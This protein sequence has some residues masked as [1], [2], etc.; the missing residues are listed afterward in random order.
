MGH[1]FQER[2][3]KKHTYLA[4]PEQSVLKE[5]DGTPVDLHPKSMDASKPSEM[6]T[7]TP[8]VATGNALESDYSTMQVINK[9]EEAVE[10]TVLRTFGM[11]RDRFE[12]QHEQCQR[13]D[14]Q[15]H[16]HY[17]GTTSSGVNSAS[18]HHF[19][20]DQCG[21]EIQEYHRLPHHRRRTYS[22]ERQTS[23]M[24][25]AAQ[26]VPPCPSSHSL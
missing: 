18:Q 12:V 1:H 10:D 23:E 20:H 4:V 26:V 19:D 16:E 8:A 3:E 2:D 21:E 13:L 9:L 11:K 7:L 14:R 24:Q 25:Q 15:Q 17:P 6:P 22:F 5:G